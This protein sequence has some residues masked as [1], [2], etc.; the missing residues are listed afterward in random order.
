MKKIILFKSL[1]VSLILMATIFAGPFT[2]FAAGEEKQK[3]SIIVH[4]S[5]SIAV[6][7]TIAYISIGV[8]TF[9]KDVTAAQNENSVK[10]DR[11]YKAL[12]AAG[13][14]KNKTKTIAYNINPRYDYKNNVASLAG[15]NVLN[16]IRVTLTDL[17]KVGS[18]LDLTVKEGVNQS[19]SITFA[20]TDEERNKFYLS[21]LAEAV[22]NA[23]NK[24][25]AIASAAG[26]TIGKPSNITE[27]LSAQA[28]P[29]AYRAM[30]AVR[31]S[32]ETIPTPISEGELTI[33]A[34]VT[35][36]YGY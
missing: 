4:G 3:N 12:A 23:A 30:D 1:A 15:Y 6:S 16:N 29:P 8:T 27:N 21:V 32:S 17:N 33:V 20:I 13:V 14:S 2:T 28:A 18:I 34:D 36:V 31:M 9:N 22:A 11:V 35:V 10:M 24:A 7:P 19:N 5:S 26:V 25:K